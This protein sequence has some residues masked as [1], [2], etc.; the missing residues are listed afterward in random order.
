MWFKMRMQRFF[1]IIGVFVGGFLFC[2]GDVYGLLSNR[3][4]TLLVKDISTLYEKTHQRCEKE[5]FG[6]NGERE[7]IASFLIFTSVLRGMSEKNKKAFVAGAMKYLCASSS[8]SPQEFCNSFCRV[9][10]AI[11][12]VALFT[13]KISDLKVPSDLNQAF[14][15]TTLYLL[16]R[17]TKSDSL[18]IVSL[19]SGVLKSESIREDGVFRTLKDIWFHPVRMAKVRPVSTVMTWGATLGVLA[20]ICIAVK[21]YSKAMDKW[22]RE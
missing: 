3:Q 10:S 19:C 13:E 4:R 9:L 8:L 17:N 7:S 14:V 12:P 5:A 6:G 2:G 1:V 11:S 20:V 16:Y 15:L 21:E 18:G 22:K